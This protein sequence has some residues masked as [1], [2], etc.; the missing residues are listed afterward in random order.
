MAGLVMGFQ[1]DAYSPLL[2]CVAS[3]PGSLLLVPLG[4][5]NGGSGRWVSAL[6]IGSPGLCLAGLGLL[7]SDLPAHSWLFW[8]FWGV[9]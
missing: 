7:R 5:S 9:I 8:S 2:E 4:G 6:Y 1:W 3:I